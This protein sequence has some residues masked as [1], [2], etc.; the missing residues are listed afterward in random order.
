MPLETAA[1]APDAPHRYPRRAPGP[2]VRPLAFDPAEAEA[3]RAKLA[4]GGN[5]SNVRAATVVRPVHR[6]DRAPRPA[7]PVRLGEYAWQAET[8]PFF[9]PWPGRSSLAWR[10]ERTRVAWSANEGFQVLAGS[11]IRTLAATGKPAP[12][13]GD[14]GIDWLSPWIPARRVPWPLAMECY[15]VA[16]VECVN[17]IACLSHPFADYVEYRRWWIHRYG[18]GS[19]ADGVPAWCVTLTPIHRDDFLLRALNLCGYTERSPGGG[20]ELYRGGHELDDR[21]IWSELQRAGCGPL[22]DAAGPL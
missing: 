4:R 16:K 18:V 15:T 8:P 3:V 20:Y 17:A 1:A 12:K 5:P 19:W 14:P 13:A 11:D 2:A 21:W 7:F 10:R 9:P 6:P 22:P